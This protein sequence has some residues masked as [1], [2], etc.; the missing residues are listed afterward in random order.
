MVIIRPSRLSDNLPESYLD[1]VK[2]LAEKAGQFVF[3]R[4][5]Q[6][7]AVDYLYSASLRSLSICF[8]LKDGAR[9]MPSTFDPDLK[10][11]AQVYIY[12]TM[13][14]YG[15]KINDRAVT[16]SNGYDPNPIGTTSVF[17]YQF[18]I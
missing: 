16:D 12:P 14:S 11:F 5:N 3:P 2:Y 13:E 1:F 9:I 8:F 7:F 18:E 4:S 6:C 15:L 10:R 17:W